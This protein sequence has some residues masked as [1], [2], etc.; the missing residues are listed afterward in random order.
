[1]GLRFFTAI[2]ILLASAVMTASG[3]FAQTQSDS[4]A[5]TCDIAVQSQMKQQAWLEGQREMEIAQ[6]LILKPDSVLEYSCF[7]NEANHWGSTAGTFSGSLSNA[8]NNLVLNAL[9]AYLT[10]FGHLFLGGTY[11]QEYVCQQYSSRDDCIAGQGS[12]NT[13]VCDQCNGSFGTGGG[14]ASGSGSSST[15]SPQQMVWFLA[16]CT[17]VDW[18]KD[19]SGDLSYQFPLTKLVNKDIRDMPQTCPADPKNA[20]NQLLNTVLPDLAEFPDATKNPPLG[21]DNASRITG[22]SSG[23]LYKTLLESCGQPVKTG[24]K[25][26]PLKVGGQVYDDAVCIT[27]GCS[28]V[29]GSCQ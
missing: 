23:K 5:P 2:L 6:R 29:N 18:Q 1:M 27:P 11:K 21:V 4:V 8:V 14:T 7:K 22:T 19:S 25:V 20:R 17:N 16:K 28:Y 9:S 15:C 12:G 3:A 24:F 26:M 10:N 13:S